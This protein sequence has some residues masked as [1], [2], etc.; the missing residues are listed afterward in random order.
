M[1]R[2]PWGPGGQFLLT[3]TF[4]SEQA[5]TLQKKHSQERTLMCPRGEVWDEE[6]KENQALPGLSGP[7]GT[8]G[9]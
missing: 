5:E 3:Y 6:Q 8:E 9:M 7:A 1:N 2:C 4:L